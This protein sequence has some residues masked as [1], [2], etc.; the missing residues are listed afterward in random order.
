MQ[1]ASTAYLG[2]SSTVMHYIFC[3]IFPFIG[4]IANNLKP[5]I[6]EGQ[7]FGMACRVH[8]HICLCVVLCVRVVEVG[9]RGESSGHG[10]MRKSSGRWG[11][12]H[13]LSRAAGSRGSSNSLAGGNPILLIE[14]NVSL[15]FSFFHIMPLSLLFIILKLIIIFSQ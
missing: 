3:P 1:T 10:S 2:P 15:F 11:S 7:H 9:R 12:S 4:W 5:F 6:R 13:S 8:L 14:N